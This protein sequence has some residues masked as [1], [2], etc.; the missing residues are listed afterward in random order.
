[1]GYVI[2]TPHHELPY[3]E[4]LTRIFQAFD[5]PLDD[6]EAEQLVKTDYYDKTFL[7]L[8]SLKRENNVWWFGSGANRR[9]DEVENEEE[10][11]EENVQENEQGTDSEKT[12]EEHKSAKSTPANF[13]WEQV[14]EK[15]K[16]A[17]SKSVEDYFDAEE[18]ETTIDEGPNASIP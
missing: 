18:G 14:E 10:N 15:T 17:G 9:R 13:E 2:N 16:T 8:C 12:V 4:L 3:G 5:V 1:M 11:E 6:N 7:G